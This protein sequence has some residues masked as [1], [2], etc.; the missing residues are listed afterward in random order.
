M[1]TTRSIEK[2]AFLADYRRSL[3]GPGPKVR[4]KA[5]GD[6]IQSQNRHDMRWCSCEK[7]AVDGGDSYLRLAGEIDLIEV[8][9]NG[10]WKTL[11]EEA[12]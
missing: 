2:V 6:V 10:E 3:G 8:E 1:F 7:I 9:R 11:N 12:T 4:C 5:C